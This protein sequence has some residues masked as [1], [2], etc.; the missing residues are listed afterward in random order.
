MPMPNDR[1]VV[2]TGVGA[3]TPLATTAEETWK[4][5]LDG[6]S[7]IGP[8]TL[9]NVEGCPT[10][11][12]GE[13]D[14]SFDACAEFA[15]I[16]PFAGFDSE[17]PPLTSAIPR[18]DL[19]KMGRFIHFA[20]VAGFEAYRTSGLD[21]IRAEIDATRLGVNIGVG[22]GGLPEIQ[23]VHDNFLRKGFSRITPFFIPQTIP[24]LATGNLSIAL[25]FRGPNMCN[26]TACSSSAHSVGE[27]WRQI[28]RG[29]A[30]VMIAGGAEAVICEL[31]IGGF[32]SMKAL[33]TR[34]DTPNE[35]SR[36]FDED[37]DG[38]VMG[39]GAAAI[40]LEELEF[41][42]RRGA[43][44]IAEI[45][46]YGLSSDAY[47]M[48]LP[49]PEG[50]GGFRA[51][52]MAIENADIDADQLDYINAHGTSTPA[53]DTEEA[54]AI[55]KLFSKPPTRLNVSSTKSMTGHLLG[56]AGALELMFCALSIRDGIIPPTINL[57]R[58]DEACE[59]LGIDF[60]ANK[61]VKKD[62]QYALS[63]SFGFGGTN[64]SLILKKYS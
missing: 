5:A 53:G 36:P 61:A 6:Q 29:D 21:R 34:N 22:M 55:R 35:A 10:K 47:H 1:R 45:V 51:M 9:C 49:A 58:L 16:N 43:N 54:F 62:I 64:A 42:K 52:K 38:F 7:G 48:T 15:P 20:M 2:I 11:I 24:N 57:D 63:N 4:A 28:Q 60:T 41:A 56:A 31:G 39:E 27:S 46:G 12:A 19:K 14:K 50:E 33:S 18:K 13:V 25:N 40:V 32:S 8:I 59:D 30:D 44:I 37:R 3:V 26:V 23:A 17:K